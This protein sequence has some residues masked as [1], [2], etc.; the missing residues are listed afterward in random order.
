MLIDSVLT[1]GAGS[2]GSMPV[3]LYLLN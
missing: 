3:W 1:I 2:R